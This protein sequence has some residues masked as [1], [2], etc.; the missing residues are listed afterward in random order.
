MQYF[1]LQEMVQVVVIFYYPA[2]VLSE[3]SY[4]HG[5]DKFLLHTVAE[6]N[7]VFLVPYSYWATDRN[8]NSISADVTDDSFKNV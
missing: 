5:L 6:Q 3:Q 7:V 1:P 8:G 4:L 2:L